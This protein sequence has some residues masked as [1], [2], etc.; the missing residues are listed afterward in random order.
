LID[1]QTGPGF[2]SSR[3]SSKLPDASIDAQKLELTVLQEQLASMNKRIDEI[4]QELPALE[5]QKALEARLKRIEEE[6]AKVPELPARPSF[7]PAISRDRSGIPAHG[8]SGQVS[9][10]ASARRG[11][12]RSTRSAPTIGS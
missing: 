12:S 7:R 2:P 4:Q 6:S 9:A 10:A 1:E 11:S 5:Q 3:Q 8:R